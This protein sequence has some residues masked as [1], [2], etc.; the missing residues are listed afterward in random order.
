[1][2]KF[3]KMVCGI[4]FIQ[5]G[6]ELYVNR[7]SRRLP[8]RLFLDNYIPDKLYSQ[9]HELMPI[10]CVDIVVYNGYDWTILQLRRDREP[11]KGSMWF[12]GG[13]LLRNEKLD[14]AAHRIVQSETGLHISNLICL[15]FDETIF[16]ADPFGHNNGSHTINIVYSGISYNCQDISINN[17]HSYSDFPGESIWHKNKRYCRNRWN[18]GKSASGVWFSSRI[19]WNGR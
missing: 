13:R 14:D 4:L 18:K 10:I 1:M 19:K 6:I 7:W 2:F 9:I 16:N 17:F 11:E 3:L 15:G 12:P 8:G 5:I